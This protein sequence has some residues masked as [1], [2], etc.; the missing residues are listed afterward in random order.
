MGLVGPEGQRFWGGRVSLSFGVCFGLKERIFN[1]VGW[2]IKIRIRAQDVQIVH[3]IC[4]DVHEGGYVHDYL[5]QQ[6]SA[7]CCRGV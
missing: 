3:L 2:G 7:R 1:Q 5:E 6:R 4:D